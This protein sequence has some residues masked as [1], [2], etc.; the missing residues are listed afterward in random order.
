LD[1]K[2]FDPV[3][4]LKIFEGNQNFIYYPVAATNAVLHGKIL[5]NIPY[6]IKSP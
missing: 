6:G 2:Y 5:K 1:G 3:E 4:N